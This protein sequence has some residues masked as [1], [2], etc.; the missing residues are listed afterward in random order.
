M[1]N[2]NPRAS[3][4]LADAAA[5]AASDALCRL[6]RTEI[7][8]R[9]GWIPFSRFMELALYAP[10]L[11]YYS[12]GARKFGAGG[13]FI[14]AP[15]LTP[16][17]AQTLA[18]QAAQVALQ[19][20]SANLTTATTL[21]GIEADVNVVLGAITQVAPGVVPPQISAGIM[22]AQVLLPLIEATVAQIQNPAAPVKVGAVVGAMS[23]GQARLVLMAAAQK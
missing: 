22:A 5:L 23:P 6:I 21:S 1:I 9:G 13:D 4:P 3:L 2:E 12:G 16:L 19:G 14:T 17:F 10:G 8:A 18:A 20:A 15:E 11:G 7:A